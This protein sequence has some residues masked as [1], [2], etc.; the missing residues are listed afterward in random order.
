MAGKLVANSL[1]IFYGLLSAFPVLAVSLLMGGVTPGEFWRVSLTAVNLLFLS[2]STGMVA[3]AICRDERR[4]TS[5]AFFILL[6]LLGIAPLVQLNLSWIHRR[7]PTTEWLI[8]SPAFAAFAAFTSRIR[9]TMTDYW[10]ST[11]ITQVYA[12]CLLLLATFLVPRSWQ[13]KTNRPPFLFRSIWRRLFGRGDAPQN[14]RRTRLLNI[15]PFLWLAFQSA[16]KSV[17]VWIGLV[18][19]TG[20]WL[21]GYRTWPKDWASLPVYV[22]TAVVLHSMLKFWLASE[23]CFRFVHDRK[24][25][26]L[27]L[28]LSTPLNVA[29]I[30]HGQRL[31]LLRQ[32]GGPVFYVLL[33][34]LV[35]LI[36]GM[37]EFSAGET[38]GR[39]FWI[40]VWLAGMFIFLMDLNAL[41]WMSMWMGL[42]NIKVNRASG[43]AISRILIL[44]WLVFS[45]SLTLL[46]AIHFL[47]QFGWNEFY[48]LG[49]WTALCVANNLIFS[50]SS[51]RSLNTQFR[52]IATQRF[53]PKKLRFKLPPPIDT[54]PEPV[55]RQ[56]FRVDR[57]PPNERME[58]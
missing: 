36:L 1:N 38:S 49:Y 48:L 33:I 45:L 13:D 32:F 20:L 43:M 26:A 15:N 12:W 14:Q 52:E 3:S 9:L 50:S 21:W 53:A 40:L 37:K 47:S 56:L 39:N 41:S 35:F 6:M 51:K 22:M 18:I 27:E 4:A 44:P 8:F 7:A 16:W 25:G 10:N 57:Q 5:L 34:D 54:A 17:T 29:E 28:L 46:G 2:L 30:T 11:V 58:V 23:A 42:K 24:T 55:H 31:A 19:L